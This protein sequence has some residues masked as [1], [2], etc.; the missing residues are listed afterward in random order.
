MLN[1]VLT[2]FE[3]V[4]LQSVFVFLFVFLLGLYWTRL[5]KN[6]PPG[7]TGWPV[8]GSAL[9]L[10][11]GLSHHVFTHWSKQYGEVFSVR[12]GGK[13]VV[14]LNGLRCIKEALHKQAEVFSDR[15]NSTVN[16]LN[17]IKGSI[18]EESGDI[19]KVRRRFGIQALKSFG[20]GKK[21]IEHSINE[22]S[23]YLLDGFADQEG[24]PFDPTHQVEITVSNVICKMCIGRRFNFLDPDITE[25]LD[26]SH[27]KANSRRLTEL[28]SRIVREHRDSHDKNDIRDVIDLLFAEVEK[29]KT[30]GRVDGRFEKDSFDDEA[31]RGNVF[32][33]FIDGTE[34][35]STTL[36]WLVMFMALHPNIQREV[37]S[38]IDDV[39]GG[40]RQP[41]MADSPYMP[42]TNAVILETLRIRPVGPLTIPHQ[43][44][45]ETTLNVY[46]VPRNTCV[47]INTW[48]VHHDPATWTEPEKYNPT[49]FLSADGKSV[50][51]HE[52]YIPFGTGRR[53]CVGERL[54][55]TE[56]FLIFVNLLQ[57]FSLEFPAEK[58]LP[59]KE[60]LSGIILKPGP[61]EICVTRRT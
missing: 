32:G 35:T 34:T 25:I 48:A 5:P 47:L 52:S 41:S 13:L 20:M 10:R 60:G 9:A 7:P 23:R 50:V 22:E 21:I 26:Y 11:R 58:L 17:G 29:R 40:S 51:Q 30:S 44:K 1:L 37:Q 39:I 14:V 61:F 15:H 57:Q 6:L 55:R 18:S 56:L 49:R 53:H 59:S 19:W 12:L 27:L 8:I 16:K 31:I 24:Q 45:E 46:T 43:T 42:Y 2:L 38:E 54:A 3:A 33:L 36:L 4:R 28:F